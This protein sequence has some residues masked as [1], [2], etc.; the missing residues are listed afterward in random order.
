MHDAQAALDA[1]NVNS[2]RCKM[3][4]FVHERDIAD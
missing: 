4:D 3:N 2:R 1:K